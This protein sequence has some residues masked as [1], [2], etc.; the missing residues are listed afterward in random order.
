MDFCSH[1]NEKTK[2]LADDVVDDVTALKR[3]YEMQ[4]RKFQRKI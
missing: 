2:A 4:E 1:A 3:R